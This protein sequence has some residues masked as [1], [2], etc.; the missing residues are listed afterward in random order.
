MQQMKEIP[1]Q[2]CVIKANAR[3]ESGEIVTIGP[4]KAM[5]F[6]HPPQS[7][8]Q[9]HAHDETHV[10]II[11]SGQMK[12]FMEGQV[13]EVGPGDIVVIP[14]GIAHHFET[15]SPQGADVMCLCVPK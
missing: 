12:F 7:K 5:I 8:A 3:H 2:P 9:E 15:I 1:L 13:H 10:I 11:R 14:P 6:S 4:T